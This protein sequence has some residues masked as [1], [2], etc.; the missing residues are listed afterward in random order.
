MSMDFI[1]PFQLTLL[2]VCDPVFFFAYGIF[3]NMI[4]IFHFRI[5]PHRFKLELRCVKD[6][7]RRCKTCDRFDL[8]RGLTLSIDN[9]LVGNSDNLLAASFLM[10]QRLR[11]HPATR[12][13]VGT[14]CLE[15]AH[16]DEQHEP[17]VVPGLLGAGRG[18]GGRRLGRPPESRR[19]PPR[20]RAECSRPPSVLSFQGAR[21]H[22]EP[23]P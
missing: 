1:F 18:P 23:S 11:A 10:S 3:H 20:V 4:L 21:V 19:R 2:L 5:F 9:H 15:R 13:D 6:D 7:P 22:G 17:A 16:R 14:L 8:F 12:R